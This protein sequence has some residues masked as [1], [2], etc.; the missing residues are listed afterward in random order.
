MGEDKPQAL[1]S[2][3]E[4]GRGG[5]EGC[6]IPRYPSTKQSARDT[7]SIFI[8]QFLCLSNLWLRAKMMPVKC[9]SEFCPQGLCKS[10]GISFIHSFTHQTFLSVF[11]IIALPVPCT[12]P[13][14][15]EVLNDYL[16]GTQMR[17]EMRNSRRPMMKGPGACLR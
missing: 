13:G 12:L 4:S 15:E 6:P 11:P 17:E 1:S 14:S 8:E 3:I 7:G 2:D 9:D 10:L 5:G 16:C